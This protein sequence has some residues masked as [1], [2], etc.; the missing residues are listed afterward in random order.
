MIAAF[1][2]MEGSDFR[3]F[4]AVNRALITLLPKKQGAVEIK[5]FRPVSLIHSLPKL[6][7]KV[8]ANRLSLDLPKI[9]GGH[10]SA[11]V[12]GRSMHDNFMLVQQTV[13][14][15]HATRGPR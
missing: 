10:Q 5:D 8:L 11:F 6:M 4:G 9:V 12:R 15:L 2:A 14:R 13:R 1:R 3:G 7:A